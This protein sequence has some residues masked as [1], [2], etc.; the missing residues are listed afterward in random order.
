M[1]PNIQMHLFF[2]SLLHDH[3]LFLLR[4]ASL[5][6]VLAAFWSGVRMRN[7]TL[8]G[9]FLLLAA[10]LLYGGLPLVQWLQTGGGHGLP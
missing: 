8:A 3:G 2:Q 1:E 5:L 7:P 4:G 9:F 10:G 6:T